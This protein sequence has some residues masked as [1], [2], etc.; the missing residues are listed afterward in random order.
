MRILEVR[1]FQAPALEE[2]AIEI[3]HVGITRTL[4]PN[5]DTGIG[6]SPFVPRIYIARLDTL[7]QQLVLLPVTSEPRI[8]LMRLRVACAHPDLLLSPL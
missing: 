4:E 8:G 6:G 5:V 1:A 7:K 2:T 3:P